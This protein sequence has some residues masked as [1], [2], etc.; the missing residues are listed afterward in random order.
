[1][2]PHHGQHS[3]CQLAQGVGLAPRAGAPGGPQGGTRQEQ[4]HRK[5]QF[6]G[7]LQGQ[8]VGVVQDVAKAWTGVEFA[9]VRVVQ[10]APS[11][12]HPRRLADQFQHI[13]PQRQA[14]GAQWSPFAQAGEDARMDATWQKHRK[15]DGCD[16]V[17]RND[18]RERP[19]RGALA[20]QTPEPG[21]PQDQR[22]FKE[23]RARM[24]QGIACRQQRGR[25][26]QAQRSIEPGVISGQPQQG[27][28]G[29]AGQACVEVALPQ[30]AE[31]LAEVGRADPGRQGTLDSGVLQPTD[32]DA[33]Q[34]CRQPG[35]RQHSGIRGTGA[36]KTKGAHQNGQQ[37]HA[38]GEHFGTGRPVRAPECGT[39]KDQGEWGERPED[40]SRTVQRCACHQQGRC[41]G[42]TDQQGHDAGGGAGA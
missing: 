33:G 35:P 30:V 31:G 26:C 8:V 39:E 42:P 16:Q 9:V 3:P 19:A 12:A 34:A 13:R 10:P 1:M 14:A 25:N 2:K 5:S 22:Q 37:A 40:R 6:H 11:P 24:G 4:G 27:A 23:A 38:Q 32:H 20:L 41:A 15:T 17:G 28:K 7:Q 29:D 21:Q 18:R 36:G